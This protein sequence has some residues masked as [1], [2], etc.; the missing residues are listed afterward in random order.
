MQD[1]LEK[2]QLETDLAKAKK[3]NKYKKINEI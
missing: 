3:I 2:E 1:K